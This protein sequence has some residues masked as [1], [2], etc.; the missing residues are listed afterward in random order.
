MVDVSYAENDEPCTSSEDMAVLCHKDIR[1][2]EG[3]EGYPYFCCA[4]AL[5]I[6]LGT[7]LCR[8]GTENGSN[9]FEKAGFDKKQKQYA[10]EVSKIVRKGLLNCVTDVDKV[11]SVRVFMDKKGKRHIIKKLVNGLGEHFV[12]EEETKVNKNGVKYTSTSLVPFKGEYEIEGDSYTMELQKIPNAG[13]RVYSIANDRLDGCGSDVAMPKLTEA[14]SNALYRDTF[15]EYYEPVRT[16]V[17]PENFDTYPLSLQSLLVRQCYVMGSKRLRNLW[18]NSGCDFS[19]IDGAID[20]CRIALEKRKAHK[21]DWDKYNVVMSCYHSKGDRKL[22]P[23]VDRD[24]VLCCEDVK[25]PQYTDPY[26]HLSFLTEIEVVGECLRNKKYKNSKNK[27]N[28]DLD[29][30]WD[31]DDIEEL[32]KEAQKSHRKNKSTKT[33]KFNFRRKKVKVLEQDIKEED[34]SNE[35]I[36]GNDDEWVENNVDEEI[37]SNKDIFNLKDEEKSDEEQLSNLN[38]KLFFYE[39]ESKENKEVDPESWAGRLNFERRYFDK[40]IEEKY[41]KPAEHEMENEDNMVDFMYKLIHNN[42]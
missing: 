33:S 34:L 21:T 22:T 11:T 39:N 15:K 3:Y 12:L 20:A 24:N 1:D 14:Q 26:S 2:G 17:G 31:I 18:S 36:L 16:L 27:K 37:L 29:P 42:R 8:N 30:F 19:T 41:I 7:M 28:E 9:R 40:K 38:N 25:G 23:I 32:Y 35:N 10:L 6:G 4:G 13:V 5:T